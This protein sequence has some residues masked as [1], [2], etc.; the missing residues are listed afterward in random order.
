MQQAASSASQPASSYFSEEHSA[1]VVNARMGDAIDPRLKQVM[2]VLVKHLHAAVKEIEPT[3]EEWLAAIRFLTETGQMCN[4][5]R[6]EYILLSDVL[7]VSM[8]VDAIN[9]RRPS[10]A[11]PNTILGPFYVA[12]APEYENGAN[13][14]LD[15][16]G[17]P[18]IVTG[19]VTDIAGKPIPGA[20][21]EVWQ[22]NDDGYY[23]VQQKG[24]QPDSN[25]R[26][27]FTSDSEG[28]YSFKS[29]KPRH[30]PIPSDG[31]VGKL[32]GEMGRHP[33][34]A[35]HLHFIVTAPGYEPVITH[36][37]TPDCPYLPEDA[38]FGVKRELIAE[39]RKIDDI[40]A[41]KQAGFDA[42]FWSVTWDFTLAPT[43]TRKRTS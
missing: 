4:E 14:C 6:Q 41:A 27:V 23:D 24:I 9:H 34:R 19:R 17:E 43:G 26:G 12:N 39:F 28:G 11:T 3:H 33:N 32:L 37:F 31:P 13:I 38:V 25:L 22:T 18:L 1:D 36:I 16:K 42:P 20:K 29:V 15:G 2:S 5:W 8:L 10:G 7:G 21:L 40:E 30:Y 35:A